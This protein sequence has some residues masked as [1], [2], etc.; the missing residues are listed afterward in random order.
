MKLG[1]LP[2]HLTYCFWSMYVLCFLWAGIQSIDTENSKFLIIY[3][4]TAVN[5]SMC[6]A[7]NF[8]FGTRAFSWDWSEGM[9]LYLVR[10][11]WWKSLWSALFLPRKCNWIY[12]L[13]LYHVLF[14][15]DYFKKSGHLSCTFKISSFSQYKFFTL[16][17]LQGRERIQS[18]LINHWNTSFRIIM[19]YTDGGGKG[20]FY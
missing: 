12:T 8:Y 7:T 15:K 1:I 6:C 11:Q 20:V 17:S 10:H 3:I 5:K 18:R 2:V 14:M 9:L 13:Q 19:T 16:L 4:W